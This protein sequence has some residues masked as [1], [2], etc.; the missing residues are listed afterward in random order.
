[1]RGGLYAM[2]AECTGCKVTSIDPNP[3]YRGVILQ[4]VKITRHQRNGCGYVVKVGRLRL[5]LDAA[6]LTLDRLKNVPSASIVT[7]CQH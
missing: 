3:R 2:G 1:M 6:L 5:P 7:G 4:I